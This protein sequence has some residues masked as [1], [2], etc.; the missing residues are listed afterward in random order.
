[1]TNHSDIEAKCASILSILGQQLRQ[2]LDNQW[3]REKGRKLEDLM[4]EGRKPVTSDKPVGGQQEMDPNLKAPE[5][6]VHQNSTRLTP[7]ETVN[8]ELEI[9]QV[10][11][12][13]AE[14]TGFE[15][16]RDEDLLLRVIQ[17]H[18]RFMLLQLQ[19]KIRPTVNL[20]DELHDANQQVV[21]ELEQKQ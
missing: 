15:E 7:L 18:Q 17:L 16:Q 19:G 20:L 3:E 1:M 11:D 10:T 21:E 12:A 2:K 9:N 5:I 6:V 14:T 4:D 8:P 13:S